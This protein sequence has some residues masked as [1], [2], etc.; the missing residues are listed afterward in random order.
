MTMVLDA[1]PAATVKKRGA[2]P[3]PIYRVGA[4][5]AEAAR[6]G[7]KQAYYLLE[8][9]DRSQRQTFKKLMP[10]I[11]ALRKEGFSF[12]QLS[13]L[14][15]SFNV[16]LQPSTVRSYYEDMIK[17]QFEECEQRFSESVM[18]M[19]KI[20]SAT[21]DAEIGKLTSMVADRQAEK[22]A[23]VSTRVWNALGFAAKETN[24]T[25]ITG[26]KIPRETAAQSREIPQSPLAKSSVEESDDELN[27]LGIKKSTK[28]VSNKATKPAFF[29]L[30]SEPAVPQLDSSNAPTTPVNPVSEEK[31]AA[32]SPPSAKPVFRCMELQSGIAPIEKRKDVPDEVYM[33]GL[34]EHPSIEGLWL[35]LDERIYGSF[36]EIID[37]DS[38]IRPETTHERLSRVKWKKPILPT[39]SSTEGAFSTL[40]PELFPAR[41][42]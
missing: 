42:T 28:D 34:L 31:L 38:V 2:A 7:L 15:N 11:Y 6:E 5:D 32:A 10:E 37:G 33:D 36:L 20:K 8:P 16:R 25:T 23:R 22:E 1:P 35:S 21:Q 9:A 18:L 26:E 14:L 39:P 12:Q 24:Q 17:E 3:G 29:N 13:E 27:L 4:I 19:A 30:D 41:K 40:N